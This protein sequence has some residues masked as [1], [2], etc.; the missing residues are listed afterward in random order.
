M[1]WS[2]LPVKL[3]LQ[4]RMPQGTEREHKEARWGTKMVRV[5]PSGRER[6]LSKRSRSAHLD[7]FVKS[8]FWSWDPKNLNYTL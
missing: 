7:S 2:L 6:G 5:K 8:Q 4:T 3:G 1:I